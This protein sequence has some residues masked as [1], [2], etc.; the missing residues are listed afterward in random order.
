MQGFSYSS[1][2]AFVGVVLLALVLGAVLAS[3]LFAMGI[4]VVA[5]L[6]FLVTRSL[7]RQRTGSA[8]A[9]D[10]P[11]TPDTAE[12]GPELVTPVRREPRVVEPTPDPEVDRTSAESF[13]ASD[14][15]A[16]Y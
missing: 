5:I 6:A 4:A 1:A 13:P 8:P 10:L 7:R 11:S 14:P 12:P 16:T 9:R 15:P 3:P 2:I